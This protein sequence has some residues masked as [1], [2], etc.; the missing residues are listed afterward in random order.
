MTQNPLPSH[1]EIF[2]QELLPRAMSYVFE[3]RRKRFVFA[4]ARA[5]VVGV[6]GVTVLAVIDRFLA[7]PDWSR[8]ILSSL[9]GLVVVLPVIRSGWRWG[10]RPGL[11]ETCR[12]YEG[13]AGLPK[14]SLV[15]LAW[16]QRNPA[17]GVSSE[18]LAAHA[19]ELAK[20]VV[21]A[22][23]PLPSTRRVV[24]LAA[25][26][27]VM[28]TA[29]MAVPNWRLPQAAARVVVFWR[30]YEAVNAVTF[31]VEPGDVDLLQGQPLTVTAQIENSSLPAVLETSRDRKHWGGIEMSPRG[32]SAFISIM[33]PLQRDRYYR[34]RVGEAMSEVFKVRVITTPAIRNAYLTSTPS[35]S[36]SSASRPTTQAL[37]TI[38]FKDSVADIR[39]GERLTLHVTATEPVTSARLFGP[40]FAYPLMIDESNRRAA[41]GNLPLAAVMEGETELRLQMVGERGGEG[42]GSLLLRTLPDTPP[43]AE[44]V[45]PADLTTVGIADEV[46]LSVLA[47]DDQGLVDL[48]LEV[49]SSKVGRD[50]PI[51]LTPGTRRVARSVR[52]SL[53]E[54]GLAPGDTVTLRLIATDTSRRKTVSPDVRLQLSAAAPDPLTFNRI[55]ALFVAARRASFLTA[56]LGR[57]IEVMERAALPVVDPTENQRDE[58]LDM[59]RLRLA[60]AAEQVVALQRSLGRC[61]RLS[62]SGAFSDSIEALTDRT[63]A[64]AAF[65]EQVAPIVGAGDPTELITWAQRARRLTAEIGEVEQ[66]L[67]VIRKGDVAALLLASSGSTT[68]PSSSLFEPELLAA[69]AA[70][71]NGVREAAAREIARWAAP[72]YASAVYESPEERGPL[73]NRLD[74]AWRVEVLR[75]D[76]VARRAADLALAARAATVLMRDDE[77]LPAD[78]SDMLAELHASHQAARTGRMVMPRVRV[79]RGPEVIREM[80]RAYAGPVGSSVETLTLLAN[81]VEVN[82]KTPIAT[83]APVTQPTT[84]APVTRPADAPTPNLVSSERILSSLPELSGYLDSFTFGRTRRRATTGP[85]TQSVQ[86]YDEA[87]VPAEYRAAVRA[88]F[89]RLKLVE[90][91]SRP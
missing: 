74:A 5:T 7:L 18:M 31:L 24:W 87:S 56:N 57:A 86:D 20:Q 78:F 16:E 38:T 17:P 52:Y 23:P 68:R 8:A 39:A 44:I 61:V 77:P 3:V 10:I 51:A 26:T 69:D 43:V 1:G 21:L 35:K 47:E 65:A 79:E 70:G 33:P 15:T 60:T 22:R 63:V 49:Q 83:T 55:E 73:A 80:L 27:V 45:R 81:E 11:V 85:S 4:F 66:A 28:A 58:Q 84:T 64:V 90:E 32:K 48:Q 76:T 46:E 36:G 62:P 2:R 13:A 75:P 53:A 91:A 19:R 82:L 59:A 37:P 12:E 9:L 88:Y 71:L 72:D 54:D 41:Y 6:A 34:V 29:L 50:V 25:A 30:G 67:T 14:E 42:W 89:Q 40:G